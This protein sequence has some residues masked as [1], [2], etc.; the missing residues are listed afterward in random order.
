MKTIATSETREK[1]GLRKGI[2]AI[3]CACVLTVAGVFAY[4]TAT[5]SVS[6]LFGLT[7]KLEVE[8]VEPNW[9]PD[10]A[11]GMLPTQT[12]A[13]DPAIHNPN[14]ADIY[15]F[16]D[17]VIP[18]KDIVT[19]NTDGTL[20]DS[21]LV[22][23]FTY[24][25]NEGWT[26]KDTIKNDDG[27][28]TY[29][30]VYDSV[31]GEE[32]TSGSIFDEVTLVNYVNDQFDTAELAQQIIINGYGMQAAGFENANAAYATYFAEGEVFI[33]DLTVNDP[34]IVAAADYCVIMA[35]SEEVIASTTAET[36]EQVMFTSVPFVANAKYAVVEE[37]CGP[38]EAITEFVA[39]EPFLAPAGASI[40]I[41]TDERK[42]FAVYSTDDNSLN[43]YKR[44]SIPAEGSS[45]EGK[46]ATNVF[47]DIENTGL[48]PP[49]FNRINTSVLSVQVVDKDIAPVNMSYWFSTFMKCSSF[50][51]NN[52]DTSKATSF[53]YAFDHCT[54]LETL[55]LSSWDTSNAKDLSY[56]FNECVNL[57][58]VK[59][60]ESWDVSNATTL[61]CM[62]Y[63]CT[64]LETL[65]LSSWDT[66]KASDLSFMFYN[67]KVL[68]TL[69]DLSSWDTSKAENMSGLF[70]NCRAIT[71]LGDLSSW[72]TE[73]VT[74][75]AN[76][77]CACI[78]LESLNVSSFNT[79]KVTDMTSMF[80]GLNSI[81]SLTGLEN[82]NTENVTNMANM[83]RYLPLAQI[84]LSSFNTT[85]V[86]NMSNMFW[87]S[88]LQ[89]IF[90][91]DS[92]S[93]D[94][95]SS[96]DGMFWA[97]N[98]IQGGAG[99]TYERTNVTSAY[100]HIDGGVDN[101]GYLTAK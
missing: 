21:A 46:T 4:L 34:A 96:S 16:A 100:A 24:E 69:G 82:W 80:D 93:T 60:L 54:A 51:L 13:K 27:T 85:N 71:S 95:V 49:W 78:S 11:Q 39:E 53:A 74:N 70:L 57:R 28:I 56:V 2:I 7:D 18:Q 59:G 91:G 6:N 87:E 86:V 84:D 99:T 1:N 32:Q 63:N 14:K 98:S 94:R 17:V 68:S 76:M 90:V 75:M 50:D 79:S 42:A 92:W 47:T 44:T 38:D 81:T 65:D 62:L 15:V 19:A 8:V 45:F 22:D 43:F 10:D 88:A 12:V 26:L 29:R 83:F 5:D 48:T 52:L 73:N 31:L 101:P 41:G 35:S 25:V 97:C 23:L 40:T 66:S 72:N 67:C 61:S 58:S 64:A 9:D 77:F 37:G 89:T 3:A 20:N 33:A 36:S 55:D 30:Y